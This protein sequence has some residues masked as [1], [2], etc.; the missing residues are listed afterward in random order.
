LPSACGRRFLRAAVEEGAMALGKWFGRLLGGGGKSE[1]SRAAAEVVEH[2]G[3]LIYPAPVRQGGQFLTAGTI[4]KDYP[5]GRKE[6]RFVR[7]DTHGS[8]EDAKRLMVQ[9][10]Q[11]LIDEMGDRLFG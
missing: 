10:A 3:F 2:N 6:H 5:D 7:A 11:R 1:A 4:A 9:K 8:E